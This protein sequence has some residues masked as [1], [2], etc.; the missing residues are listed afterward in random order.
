MPTTAP[1][2]TEKYFYLMRSAP[3]LITIHTSPS[4]SLALKSIHLSSTANLS[5]P[6]PTSQHMPTLLLKAL[7]VYEKQ[8]QDTLL[9]E[10]LPYHSPSL[11]KTPL[12]SFQTSVLKAIQKVPLGSTLS[13]GAV[14]EKS[15]HPK[16][17]RAVGS[18]CRANPLP[19]VIPCHRIVGKTYHSH[20]VGGYQGQPHSIIKHQL[21]QLEREWC[22][23]N[24][25]KN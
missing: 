3:I 4:S 7:E 20:R 10:L 16:S 5:S 19:L 2:P 12:S 21:L 11:R 24:L 15:G 9:K 23:K 17:Y 13:Y 1:L 25:R 8:G 18:I 6:P 14:A 22:Y